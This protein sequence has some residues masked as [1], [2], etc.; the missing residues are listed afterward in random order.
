[1]EEEHRE[2]EGEVVGQL[3]LAE[4]TQGLP[5][6]APPLIEPNFSL[7]GISGCPLPYI[8]SIERPREPVWPTPPEE[9][10]LG[11][12]MMPEARPSHRRAP[13]NTTSMA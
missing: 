2:T 1:M 6:P 5:G 10:L 8:C 7:A 3:L 11:S 9:P 12:V 4:L 13:L